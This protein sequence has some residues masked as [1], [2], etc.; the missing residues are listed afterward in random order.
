VPPITRAFIK[1]AL[2]YFV[3]ALLV[4]VAIAVPG[5]AALPAVGA[6]VPVYFHLF[7]VGWVTQL[8]FGVS[9]WMF[10]RHSKESPRGD[11]R[12]AATALVALNAGLCLRA[13]AEPARA[14]SPSDLW[15]WLLVL[16][17]AL[18]WLAG[19]AYVANI[20]TRVKER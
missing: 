3:A 11:E 15:G 19:V 14:L 18:Q 8:I 9:L 10:P 20:W 7:M 4:G 16:S 1:A 12:L 17:A 6:L 13:V 2:V 5:L